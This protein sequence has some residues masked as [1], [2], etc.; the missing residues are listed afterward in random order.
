MEDVRELRD[1]AERYRRM[2]LNIGDARAIVA[3][4]ELADEFDALATSFNGGQTWGRGFS[5]ETDKSS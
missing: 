4:Y 5:A 3:L 2:A 1:K